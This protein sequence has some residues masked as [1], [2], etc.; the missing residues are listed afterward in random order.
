MH[1]Y[2]PALLPL[3]MLLRESSRTFHFPKLKARST[4]F[5]PNFVLRPN[6]REQPREAVFRGEYFELEGENTYIDIK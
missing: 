3:N 5:M 6:Q 1:F 2:C 4:C